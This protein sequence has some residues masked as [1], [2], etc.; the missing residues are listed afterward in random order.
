MGGPKLTKQMR[1]HWRT[2]L[3]KTKTRFNACFT[4][5]SAPILKHARKRIEAPTPPVYHATTFFFRHS[6]GSPLLVL[7]GSVGSLLLPET[8]AEKKVQKAEGRGAH[9]LN[10]CPRLRRSR[11]NA[12]SRPRS[13]GF[14]ARSDQPREPGGGCKCRLGAWGPNRFEGSAEPSWT[15]TAVPSTSSRLSGLWAAFWCHAGQQ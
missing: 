3:I 4:C 13:N 8:T 1:T 7:R 5:V 10:E 6:P 2:L 12:A 15:E 9:T 11:R 14:F